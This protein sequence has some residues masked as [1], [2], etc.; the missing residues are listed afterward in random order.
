MDPLSAIAGPIGIVDVMVRL[1]Q[2]IRDL[3]RQYSGA[4]QTLG[5]LARQIAATEVAVQELCSIL[6]HSPD[7]FPSSFAPHLLSLAASITEIICQIQA[8]IDSIRDKA[9]ESSRKAKFLHLR[10]VKKIKELEESLRS[11]KKDLKFLLSIAQIHQSSGT[12][13]HLKRTS[14][15]L[16][17]STRIFSFS[18]SQSSLPSSSE[19]LKS[20][21]FDII[22][23]ATRPY[24]RAFASLI[25]TA[26]EAD[27]EILGSIHVSSLSFSHSSPD[28]DEKLGDSEKTPL[29]LEINDSQ[30][31]LSITPQY[32]SVGS[33]SEPRTLPIT[34]KG[35]SFSSLCW[36]AYEIPLHA[37]SIAQNICKQSFG[38][39]VY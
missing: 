39:Y 19:R 20:F 11:D 17:F 22:L 31:A 7:T 16:R 30:G 35:S 5:R 36:D 13:T 10:Q 32:C 8:H 28:H 26:T 18:E 34:T 4:L 24:Q 29:L 14:S 27:T 1:F 9:G 25:K 37:W 21:Q 15:S 38:L 6:L 12:T 2:K 23:L 33:L 3:H